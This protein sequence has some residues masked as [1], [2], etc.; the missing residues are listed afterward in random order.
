[1][2]GQNSGLTRPASEHKCSLAAIQGSCSWA[3]EQRG[4]ITSHWKKSYM[5]DGHSF[6]SRLILLFPS[7]QPYS[8]FGSLTSFL[9]SLAQLIPSCRV[10]HQYQE[11]RRMFLGQ[12]S[13]KVVNLDKLVEGEMWVWACSSTSLEDRLRPTPCTN[14][15]WV[16]NKAFAIKWWSLPLFPWFKGWPCSMLVKEKYQFWNLIDVQACRSL[17]DGR[18]AV[19]LSEMSEWWTHPFSTWIALDDIQRH[20][21]T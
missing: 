12:V 14:T 4:L 5:V 8:P 15:S 18:L 20:R 10:A 21:S 9:Q 16:Y 2:Q 17:E 7:V 19:A 3:E 13:P 6:S 11:K 1:M